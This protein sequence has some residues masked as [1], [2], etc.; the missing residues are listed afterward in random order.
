MACKA[1]ARPCWKRN[2]AGWKK[3]IAPAKT[4]EGQEHLT[5]RR[6]YAKR[7]G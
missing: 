5:K 6:R 2:T 3:V 1:R 4:G 7:H